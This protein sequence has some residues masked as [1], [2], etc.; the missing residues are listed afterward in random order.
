MIYRFVTRNT[1]EERVTQVAKKKMMLTH[2]VVQPGMSG[3][4]KANLSKK[5]ID[6]I[7]R[8]GTEE[9][10]N[11]DD[12]EDPESGNDIVYDDAAISQLLDRSQE[13]IEEKVTDLCAV[14]CFLIG[15]SLCLLLLSKHL[16]VST[17]CFF[18]L[19]ILG[20]RIPVF[21]QSGNLCY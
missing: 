11:Q 18:F 17:V 1:V 21:F 3:G 5:E 10:F 2:L 8:F 20:Q 7:L 15:S 9:L 13:G 12:P 6:D 14:C 4:N 16:G 19:G